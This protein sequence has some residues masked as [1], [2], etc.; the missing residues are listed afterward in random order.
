MVSGHVITNLTPRD[1]D[2]VFRRF[3]D[4]FYEK[5]PEELGVHAVLDNAPTNHT[6]EVRRWLWLP[7]LPVSLHALTA[8]G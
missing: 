4:L 7:P 5:V 3:L 6:S 1:R 2:D 8:L